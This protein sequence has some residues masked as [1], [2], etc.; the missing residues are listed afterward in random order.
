MVLHAAQVLQ[1]R[2]LQHHG[3]KL[4]EW[5]ERKRRAPKVRDKLRA[6]LGQLVDRQSA[7][8]C[9]VPLEAH[10]ALVELPA[11][12]QMWGPTTFSGQVAPAQ[13]GSESMHR[14]LGGAWLST[15][16]AGS[17]FHPGDGSSSGTMAASLRG[18]A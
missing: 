1:H 14:N 9:L 5:H 2:R 17:L 6:L 10:S 16:P 18:T 11:R 7:A 4:V 15:V 12:L 3:G 8:E 13:S